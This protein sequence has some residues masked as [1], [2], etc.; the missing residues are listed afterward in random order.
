M[1][2]EQL[3]LL[4]WKPPATIHAFPLWARSDKVRSVAETLAR[5]HGKAAEAYWKQTVTTLTNQLRRLGVEAAEVEAEA[6]AFFYVVQ[7]EMARLD[8][9]YGRGGAA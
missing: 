8:G 5:K 1:V 4:T 3:D 2:G 7:D 6:R 9:D